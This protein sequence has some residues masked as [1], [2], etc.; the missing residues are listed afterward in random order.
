MHFQRSFPGIIS[1]QYIGYLQGILIHGTRG[2][3]A[4]VLVAITAKVLD[5][6]KYPR[7]DNFQTHL[8]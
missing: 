1:H 4:Q 6:V 8:D 2:V 5:T 7:L 3:N